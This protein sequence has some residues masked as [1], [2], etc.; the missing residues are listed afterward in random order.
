MMQPELRPLTVRERMIDAAVRRYGRGQPSAFFRRLERYV[1]NYPPYLS[2]V[3][4]ISL[5]SIREFRRLCEAP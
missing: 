1:S 3:Y 2:E 5:A 4:D